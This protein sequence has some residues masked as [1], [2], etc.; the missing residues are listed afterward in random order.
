MHKDEY[1]RSGGQRCSEDNVERDMKAMGIKEGMAQDR[2]SW[3][4]I[5]GG[6][7]H[8]SADA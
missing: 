8:A 7:T 5:T 6:P 1:D 3:R 4:I 2:F